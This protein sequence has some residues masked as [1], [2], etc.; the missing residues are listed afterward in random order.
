LKKKKLK[1]YENEAKA[2]LGNIVYS[3]PTKLY[4]GTESLNYLGNELE[5]YG[6]NVLL[7]YGSGSIKKTGLYDKVM[8]ILK[9]KNKR[10]RIT[11]TEIIIF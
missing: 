4:F 3:N 2:M 9:E 7:V 8:S 10:I 11:T 1:S 5:H 6:K